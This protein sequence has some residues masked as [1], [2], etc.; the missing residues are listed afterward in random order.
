MKKCVYTSHTRSSTG[1]CFYWLLPSCY[2]IEKSRFTVKESVLL[3]PVS[4]TWWL[5]MHER[6]DYMWYSFWPFWIMHSSQVNSG[7]PVSFIQHVTVD[8]SSMNIISYFPLQ[9]FISRKKASM[10]QFRD[11]IFILHSNLLLWCVNMCVF[12]GVFT[13][14][15][16]ASAVHRPRITK[17]VSLKVAQGSFCAQS[18]NSLPLLSHTDRAPSGC[19]ESGTLSSVVTCVLSLL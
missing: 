11:I 14:A 2:V 18:V 9:Q 1:T 19:K 8:R 4:V 6:P 3:S 15:W 10:C 7:Y 12:V 5:W 16:K 17:C 13:C